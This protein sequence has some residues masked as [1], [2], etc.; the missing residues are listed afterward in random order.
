M[1]VSNC[2]VLIGKWDVILEVDPD[3]V[4]SVCAVDAEYPTEPIYRDPSLT[5]TMGNGAKFYPPKDIGGSPL[6]EVIWS[7]GRT[8]F[9]S[10]EQGEELVD[11]L[12]GTLKYH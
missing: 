4:L 7:G 10:K 2:R 8:P 12:S 11:L 5:E 3:G 6:G 1:G 9:F